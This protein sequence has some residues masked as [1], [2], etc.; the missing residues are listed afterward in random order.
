MFLVPEKKQE[1]VFRFFSIQQVARREGQE[2]A[3][4]LGDEGG[5]EDESGGLWNSF[6][7][8]VALYDDPL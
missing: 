6:A 5:E 1:I 4:L 2:K 7:R 3:D 8:L